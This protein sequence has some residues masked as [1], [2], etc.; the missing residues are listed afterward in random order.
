[1]SAYLIGNFTVTNPEGFAEYQD[2][3]RKTIIDHGGEYVVADATSSTVEGDPGS[4]SMVLKF[5]DMK[6]LRGWY[7]SQEYQDI[8]PL[9]RDN[10]E[11]V[12]TFASLSFHSEWSFLGALSN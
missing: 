2:L 11:G 12:I 5:A 3:V 8:L 4:F 7:D 6:A 9:R 10:S 1:M